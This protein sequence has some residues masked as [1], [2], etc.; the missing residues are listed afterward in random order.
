MA[1]F[2][3]EGA[4]FAALCSMEAAYPTS[5]PSGGAELGVGLTALS[6]PEKSLEWGTGVHSAFCRVPRLVAWPRACHEPFWESGGSR[7]PV[8]VGAGGKQA[9]SQLLT[10]RPQTGGRETTR[11]GE[12]RHSGRG[13]LAV[14][15]LSPHP[16]LLTLASRLDGHLLAAVAPAGGGDGGHPQ[17]VLLPA[18]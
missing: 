15:A 13:L 5:I 11:V 17:Q 14:S 12:N 8:L 7:G 10:A 1:R 9:A 3:N 18:V 6:T 4:V 16:R 2:W